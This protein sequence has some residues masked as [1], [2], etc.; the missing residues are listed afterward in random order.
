MS[1][2]RIFNGTFS[3]NPSLQNVRTGI[4]DIFSGPQG[5]NQRAHLLAMATRFATRGEE[6]YVTGTG[7]QA[8]P[9][10]LVVE[11]NISTH[12]VTKALALP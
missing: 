10:F 11:G 1:W 4:A 6:I 9:G 5:A 2:E 3:I 8:T 7:T 12:N